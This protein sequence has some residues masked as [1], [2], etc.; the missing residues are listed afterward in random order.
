M[1]IIF[2]PSKEMREN[3]IIDLKINSKKINFEKKTEI[4]VGTLQNLLQ[5]DIEKIMKVKNKLLFETINNIK[6]YFSLKEIP[7]I[8]M[9]NGVAYKKINLENYKID[10]INFMEENLIILS[11]L[12]GALSPLTLTKKYR[13]D[14]TMKL[15][16]FNLY[17]FWKEDVNKFITK[18]LEEDE[19]L[20]N[21]AS[22]EFAKMID[23]KIVKNFVSIDFKD[24]KDGKYKSIS[25]YVKQARGSFLNEII[26]NKITSLE[27]IKKISVDEYIF[28]SELSTKNKYIFT[29]TKK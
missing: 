8:S 20:L 11:A 21:L 25:S 16:E 6:N 29:R 4:L 15:A 28:N 12:Y 14:M 18:K 23:K 24:F 19:V 1:K 7:A 5:E 13:L 22:N 27:K 3:N 2:S 9:Y 26:I 10:E 17:N